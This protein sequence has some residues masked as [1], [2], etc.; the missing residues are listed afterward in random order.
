MQTVPSLVGTGT[1]VAAASTGLVFGQPTESPTP[2]PATPSSP[3][4]RKLFSDLNGDNRRS[5]P[6]PPPLSRPG[7]CP[8]LYS[9]QPVEEYPD[10][11]PDEPHPSP[12]A[13]HPVNVTSNPWAAG[14]QTI[15]P[16]SNSQRY[17]SNRPSD[18]VAISEASRESFS[19]HGSWIKRLSLR[20]TS[21]HGSP[22]SS[23]GPDSAFSFSQGSGAP[24]LSP[25]GSVAPQMPPN[26]LVKR[27]GNNE[28]IFVRR[29]TRQVPTL[30]RPVTSHQRSATVQQLPQSPTARLVL[31]T[32]SLDPRSRP[33]ASTTGQTN[34]PWRK[35]ESSSWT[36]FFHARRGK[37]SR[38][39]HVVTPSNESNTADFHLPGT[40]I[41]MR[42]GSLSIPYLMSPQ[43]ISGDAPRMAPA[44]P[45][46]EPA[47]PT[48]AK[49]AAD[50]SNQISL[51][52][53]VVADVP[54]KTPATGTRRSL[55]MHLGSS[56]G[57]MA[58]AGSLRRSS[59][60]SA[61][62]S[63]GGRYASD[64]VSTSSPQSSGAKPNIEELFTPPQSGHKEPQIAA[65]SVLQGRR[66]DCSSPIPSLTRLSSSQFD[67]PKLGPSPPPSAG[68]QAPSPTE[69]CPTAAPQGAP[70]ASHSRAVSKE[71]AATL[72][73]SEMSVPGLASCDDDDTDYKSDAVFDS[74]RTTDSNR[75]RMVETPLESMFDESPHG[76]TDNVKS[77]RLSIHEILG[78]P[79]DGDTR[80]MEEDEESSTP[81]RG[82]Q[83]GVE[84][85]IDSSEDRATEI[86]KYQISIGDNRNFGRLSLDTMDDDYDWARD[87]EDIL[88]NP[89]SPPSSSINSRRGPN[90]R[91]RPALTIISGNG[92]PDTNATDAGIDR[93][94]SNIFDWSEPSHDKGDEEFP[95]PRTVHGKQELALRGG[96]ANRKGFP[97]AHIRSQS[98]PNAT[99]PMEIVK[100]APKFG[101]WGI[102]TKNAS[103]DWDDD[104]E[105]EEGSNSSSG[106]KS[107]VKSLSMSVPKSIQT[108]QA[109]VKAHSGQIRELSL[110][111]SNL[112]RLCRQGRA[113]NLQQGKSATLWKEA[114]NIIALASPDDD[115]V[116]ENDTDRSSSDF[117]PVAIDERFLDEG[118][119]AAMLDRSKGEALEPDIPKNAV[120][121]E[122]QVVRRR[123]VFSPDDDIF[124][125]NALLLENE[126]TRPHTPRTPDR[127]REFHTPDGAVV[128]SVIAAMEQQRS[129]PG[130][131]PE[132][133]L[134][135]SKAKLFFDTNSLQELVKRASTVFHT[136]S[137]IVRREELLTMSP[138]ATPKHD[139]ARRGGSPAFTRVFTDPDSS[140]TRHLVRSQTSHSPL[141]RKGPDPNGLGPRMQ[142]MTVN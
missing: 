133:P 79:W 48:E 64:P 116:E 9:V 6:S 105:F 66:R 56:G 140:P 32:S 113:L 136:L 35:R 22:R 2:T 131:Q 101:T 94:R 58:R 112:K 82:I 89:L 134:K 63:G 47:V 12:L 57:W 15:P 52:S 71:G 135:P 117:D 119:D 68:L 78:N 60:G 61:E 29:G 132:S 27:S 115:E 83:P 106:S 123:S 73:G 54:E 114:E 49:A 40:R 17:S 102:S 41:H 90:P 107:P 36:S 127:V 23:V 43:M 130:R 91:Q 38:R 93:P 139:R 4:R 100:G 45:E 126:G 44:K 51:D 138:Q 25:T 122:R 108:T 118:F 97:P 28:S 87:D 67:L 31:D 80:I 72:A 20:P 34:V 81:S 103:E 128:S 33:R 30:R 18:A 85:G 5:T 3:F 86:A 19:S 59:R 11:S 39:G 96:R 7:T 65:T 95:R 55:S 84:D 10:L 37:A 92:T 16:R 46:L 120:V 1:V 141:P 99:D 50:P 98:V 8:A 129:Q 110:L 53:E 76:T 109:T 26:K 142:M 88:N 69:V 75:P 137:D 14:P 121:R 111:V 24:I 124:G 74:F 13:S 125:N 70:M 77:K 42:R 62:H 21:Q 104:F